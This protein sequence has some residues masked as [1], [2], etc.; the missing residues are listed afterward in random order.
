MSTCMWAPQEG[1]RRQNGDCHQ[2]GRCAEEDCRQEACPQ[3]S[4][5]ED[6]TKE[7]GRAQEDPITKKAAAPMKAASKAKKSSPKK[8]A[9]TELHVLSEKPLR[10]A[11]VPPCLVQV[12]G[13]RGR[14]KN[15]Y[16]LVQVQTRGMHSCHLNSTGYRHAWPPCA[17]AAPR[18]PATNAAVVHRVCTRRPRVV[19]VPTRRWW[20][21]RWCT[22]TGL[23]SSRYDTVAV[24]LAGPAFRCRVSIAF[25]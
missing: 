5:Q 19:R 17:P 2:Q 8:A 25:V 7:G 3:E 12:Q 15:S 24:A 9:K 1:D 22:C 10:A 6:H 21:A 4:I 11:L 23:A 18:Q 14:R 16:H 13:T 20:G